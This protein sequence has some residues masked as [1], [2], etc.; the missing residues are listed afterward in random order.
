[1]RPDSFSIL[2]ILQ[3]TSERK[4]GKGYR[5]F[6]AKKVREALGVESGDKIR[7]DVDGRGILVL[8]QE[9][10]KLSSKKP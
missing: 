4:V 8:E 3:T 1:L 2:L 6:L 10:R 9:R 5:L 7:V